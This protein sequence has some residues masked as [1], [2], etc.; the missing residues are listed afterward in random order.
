MEQPLEHLIELNRAACEEDRVIDLEGS[1]SAIGRRVIGQVLG[2]ALWGSGTAHRGEQP[3][4]RVG[5][6]ETRLEENP[7]IEIRP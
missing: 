7:G 3:C 1:E 4:E 2:M 6:I 5:C